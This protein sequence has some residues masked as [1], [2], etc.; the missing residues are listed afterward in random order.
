MAMR[1]K[2]RPPLAKPLKKITK[3]TDR[4]KKITDRDLPEAFQTAEL[5]FF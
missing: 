1:L 3:D 5:L 4:K 2:T